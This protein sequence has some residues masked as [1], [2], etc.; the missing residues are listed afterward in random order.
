MDHPTPGA[1]PPPS[2]DVRSGRCRV[3]EGATHGRFAL[4]FCCAALVAQLQMPLAP[5]VSMTEY[6]VTDPM[7]RRLRG[8]KDAP[9]TETRAITGSNW[10]GW[11]AGGWP[12]T[13]RGWTD[14]CGRDGTWSRQCRPHGGPDARRWMP[15][16]PGCRSWV[17]CSGLCWFGDLARPPPRFPPLGFHLLPRS[18]P[19][20]DAGSDRAGG[21][22]QPHHR[23][24]GA[25]R[26]WR[27]SGPVGPWSPG[28]W[29][30][31]GWWQQRNRR[32]KQR[33]NG[34]DQG[35]WNGSLSLYSCL[36]QAHSA[37]RDTERAAM[38]PM[39]ANT[40]DDQKDP[41]GGAAGSPP[42][43]PLCSVSAELERSLTEVARAILRLDV[44]RSVWARANRRQGGYWLLV[45]IS[46]QAPIR[47][48]ELA[49]SVELDLS[50]VSRQIPIWSP[51]AWCSKSG[52]R[53]RP[54]VVAHP[55]STWLGGP[56]G[57]VRGPAP[58]AVRGHRGLVGGGAGPLAGSLL[59]LE[60]GLQRSKEHL[61][62][63]R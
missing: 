44:P 28:S 27:P 1:S 9:V 48:S 55:L 20:P 13:G 52:T 32:P 30:S 63:G 38:A 8:Y 11:S 61:R 26:R 22:R 57:G 34:V 39:L 46:G 53:G 14:G 40:E 6:R 51:S 7:H 5:V 37:I 25:E 29:S 10:S 45:R 15:S 3:C 18:R 23:G 19:R 47:L 12:P 60:A 35:E 58:G 59:R 21:G 49:D 54:G 42:G 62:E 31:A 36:L 17:T 24:Q 56:R 33:K 50:T 16:C 43:R 2:P 41:A 4:C